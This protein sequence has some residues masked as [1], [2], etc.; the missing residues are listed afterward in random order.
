MK[1]SKSFLMSAAAVTLTLILSFVSSLHAEEHPVLP[2]G[3]S[4]PD[5]SLPGID[6]KDLFA[7]RFQ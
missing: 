3:S 7:E 5:F 4:A 1:Q 2:I 6:G